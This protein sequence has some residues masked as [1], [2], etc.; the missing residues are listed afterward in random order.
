[1]QRDATRMSAAQM[2]SSMIPS[3]NTGVRRGSASK[4]GDAPARASSSRHVRK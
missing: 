2:Q 3:V 4:D 1:L